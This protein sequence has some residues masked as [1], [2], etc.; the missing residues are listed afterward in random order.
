MP[1]GSASGAVSAP[2]VTAMVED[3]HGNLWLGTEGGGLDLARADGTVLKV[4]RNDPGNPATLPANTVYALA[5][6][7]DGHVWVATDGGGLAR[8]VDPAAAPDAIEFQVLSRADGLS[9]DTLWGIVP[10][11]RGRLWLSGNAGLM[12]FD[13]ETRAVKTYHREHGLQGEEFSFGASFRLRDGRVCFGGPGGFNIFDPATLSENT[14]PPRV[15]LTSVEVLGVRAPH[16]RR[17]LLAA[18]PRVARLSRH[19]RLS[20]LRSA[21]LHVA[22]AQPAR[23]PHDGS[24][25]RLDRSRSAAP[26][27]AD[28]PRFRRSRARGAR[29]ELGFRLE[30]ERR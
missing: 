19:D 5:V 30:R 15:A 9:S 22:G 12:R 11:A 17:A 10:D 3:T 21:G 24:D 29:G 20:R 4:F 28:E 18:R 27:H 14:Q 23:V 2:Y 25:R 26:R 1:Y 13:P 8:V 6:D 7:G 16:G